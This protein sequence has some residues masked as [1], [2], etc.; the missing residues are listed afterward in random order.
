MMKDMST[1]ILMSLLLFMIVLIVFFSNSI[2]EKKTFIKPDFEGNVVEGIPDIDDFN[3]KVV[4][5]KDGY[6]FY[7]NPI[8]VIKDGKLLVNFTSIESN[9]ILLKLRIK[10][11]NGNIVGE[12][13]ILK[14]GQY[15]KY[16]NV[17]GISKGKEISYVVMGYEK[18]SY[19]SAGTVVLKTKVGE[20]NE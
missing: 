2:A 6:N 19:L 15:V 1:Y 13:G 18:D 8:P 9:E 16:I 4:P 14:A 3:K 17:D 10:D 5:V 12:T 20:V 11:Y 7:V